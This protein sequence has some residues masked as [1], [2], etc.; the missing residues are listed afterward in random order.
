[1]QMF[2]AST[3]APKNLVKFG[4]WTSRICKDD[5]RNLNESLHVSSEKSFKRKLF[6]EVDGV[7]QLLAFQFKFEKYTNK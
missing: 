4:W 2:E 6:D 5:I 1:M 7:N 3:H